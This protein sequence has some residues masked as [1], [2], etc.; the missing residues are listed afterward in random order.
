MQAGDIL[1]TGKN[2][3]AKSEKTGTT[4][5]FSV[6]FME[7]YIRY[8]YSE[9]KNDNI[10]FNPWYHTN[11]SPNMLTLNIINSL[12]CI[13]DEPYDSRYER[14]KHLLKALLLQCKH[15]ISVEIRSELSKSEKTFQ[16][17]IEYISNNYHKPINRNTISNELDLNHCYI[18]RLFKKYSGH[19]FNTYLNSI[20]MKNAKSILTNHDL[21]IE[22]VAIQCGFSNT[23]YFIKV[24]KKFYGLTPGKYK[25][26][27]RKL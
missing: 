20:R 14:G 19:N 8:V 3:W 6:V 16:R 21:S 22:R 23:A 17:I 25:L 7:E 15:E 10:I 1:F 5:T 11:N 18:S 26:L 27:P 9:R 13:M 12:N 24:F 4:K 2:G